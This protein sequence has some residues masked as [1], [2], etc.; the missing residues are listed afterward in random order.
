MEKVINKGDIWLVNLEPSRK[1]ELGKR[2]RP[3]VIIQSNDASEILDTVTLVPVSS[4]VLQHDEIHI[5]LKPTKPNGLSKESVAICSH[6]YTISKEHLI[7]KLGLITKQELEAIIRA[8]L[9][10]LDIDVF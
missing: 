7:K 9:L 10:H 2:G 6:I 3:S 4:D 5:F 1:G 8:I